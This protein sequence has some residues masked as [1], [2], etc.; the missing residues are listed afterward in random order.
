[1]KQVKEVVLQRKDDRP[2]AIAVPQP[3]AQV[4]KPAFT[5]KER[6]TVGSDEAIIVGDGLDQ[7]KDASFQGKP[8]Q[9]KM[10]DKALR[11]S[12][13]KAAG[14]TASSATVSIDLTL[15]SGKA[16]VSLDVVNSKVET[17]AK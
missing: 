5:A 7:V 15:T 12:G 17:V 2:V 4:K 13:L 10:E 14:A 11:L 1:M 3:D 9:K 6:V 16:T 8:L